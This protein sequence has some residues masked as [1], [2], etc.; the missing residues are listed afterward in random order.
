M[1]PVTP[2]IVAPF[3]L[4]LG[5]SFLLGIG[6]REYYEHEGKV[7]TFGT[8]RTFIFIGM[9]GFVMIQLPGLGNQAYLTGFGAL[10][11]L[12]LI[13]YGEKI[14][15]RKS[16]GM[17]GVLIAL[18][19]YT[20]GPIALQFPPWY[21]VLLA[22]SILLVLHSKGRIRRF[23]DRLETDEV[24]T[25]CK[26]LAIVGV[27]LPL[28]PATMPTGDGPIW[29]LL[30]APPVTPKQIW[31][32]VVI[33]TAIS[34]LGYVL[35]TYLYPRKGLLLAGLVGGLYSSTA[36]VVVLAKRSKRGADGD[37][38][39]ATAILLAVSMMYVRLLALVAIFRLSAALMVGPALIVL[40]G[41]AAGYALWLHRGRPAPAAEGAAPAPAA[42]GGGGAA[43]RALR[44][45]PLELSAALIFAVLFAVVSFVTKYVLESFQ[46]AGLRVM[47]FVVGFSDITPFV[48]SLLQGN[49]GIGD[50]QIVQAVIIASASNN[51]LKLA[52]TYLLGTRRTANLAAVGLLGLVGL[53]LLYAVFGL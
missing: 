16:H 37:H 34:Y 26:F 9:L 32:A 39:T 17:I 24:V 31:V 15:R 10:T 5:I 7:D 36:T 12:L 22:V 30:A 2:D 23:S 27:V 38:E 33:T 49:F 44:R 28:I 20:V 29:R 11:L 43:E 1:P 21:L 3:L 25:A 42:A 52:Y 19:T 53:S 8:V 40:S 13:Y 45:N 14:L 46:D 18:L 35:Q 6:L 4:T 48:V 50:Q 51:V 47:S 41:A